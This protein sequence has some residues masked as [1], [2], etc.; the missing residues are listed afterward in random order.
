MQVTALHTACY[1]DKVRNHRKDFFKEGKDEFCIHL[2]GEPI[3]LDAI[4]DEDL[5]D[6]LNEKKIHVI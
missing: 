6:L 4:F 2:D 5:M 3:Q 1:V